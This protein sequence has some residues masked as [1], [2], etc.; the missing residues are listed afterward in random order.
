MK[1]S[2]SFAGRLPTSRFVARRPGY[3]NDGSSVSGLD[4]SATNPGDSSMPE[5]SAT[6][7]TPCDGWWEQAFHGRQPME[8]LHLTIDGRV[9]GGLGTDIIGPFT[10][11]GLITEDGRVSIQK[12]YLERHSVRY[13]GQHDGEGRMWG[14][15][16]LPGMNG[17]WMIALRRAA[18]DSIDGIR[19]IGPGRGG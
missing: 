1:L 17:R 4:P 10:L 3:R 13:E 12:D 9:V 15:W 5:A 6:D 19:Q 2:W 8:G 18:G 11:H 14:V 16:A 7:F